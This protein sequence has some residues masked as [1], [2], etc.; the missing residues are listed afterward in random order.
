MLK[1]P[2]IFLV[3]V[4]LCFV[5][6]CKKQRIKEAH[7]FISHPIAGHISFGTQAPFSL[8]FNDSIKKIDGINELEEFQIELDSFYVNSTEVTPSIGGKTVL[9]SEL[10]NIDFDHNF[11]FVFYFEYWAQ[12]KSCPKKIKPFVLR[13]SGDLVLDFRFNVSVGGSGMM[14]LSQ[15]LFVSIP[16]T[17]ENKPVNA[18]IVFNEVGLFEPNRQFEKTYTF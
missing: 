2:L 7:W 6:G 4:G 16:R 8:L 14:P 3:L 9:N 10:A 5:A 1:K 17:H 11:L 18:R 15:Y 13:S 12:Q